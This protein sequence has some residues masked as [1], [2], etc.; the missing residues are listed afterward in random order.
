MKSADLKYIFLQVWRQRLLKR[1][2]VDVVEH[3]SKILSNG[4]S[5]HASFKCLR[6]QRELDQ[7]KVDVFC[8]QQWYA[9]VSYTSID[10][11]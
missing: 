8:S 4:T 2:L 11:C 5:S 10:G 7:E 6:S 3:E 1:H 9:S